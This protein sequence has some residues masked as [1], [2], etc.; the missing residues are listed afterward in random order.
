MFEKILFFLY[1]LSSFLRTEKNTKEKINEMSFG[2]L[3]LMF[4]KF[5][6][7]VHYQYSLFSSFLECCQP[8]YDIYS[9]QENVSYFYV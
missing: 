9:L 2:I 3:K 4:V 5:V 1:F 7:Q 8:S 6:Y